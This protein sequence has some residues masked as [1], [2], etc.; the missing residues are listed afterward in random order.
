V[1]SHKTHAA[2][3]I[4][5]VDDDTSVR[6]SISRLLESDGFS[7]LAF[8]DSGSFLSHIDTH[9]VRLVVLDIWRDRMI[10]MKFLAQLN[11][12][13]PGTR[14]IFITGHEDRDAE[15]TVMQAGAFAFF[16]KP[17]DDAQFLAAVHRALGSPLAR[18]VLTKSAAPL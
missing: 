12:R 17:L 16:T 15:P 3:V 5:L 7:V 8:S 10:G 11:T 13:S 6:K 1:P 9:R 4:C 2:E 14:V 18:G